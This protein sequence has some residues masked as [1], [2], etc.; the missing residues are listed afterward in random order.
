MRF[1]SKGTILVVAATVVVGAAGVVIAADRDSGGERP[2]RNRQVVT[3]KVEWR[4]LESSLVVR[5]S[6]VHVDEVTIAA[7]PRAEGQSASVVTGAPPAA[8]SPV[9]AGRSIIEINGRPIVV[10][11]MSVPLFRDI[12][13]GTTGPDVMSLQQELG[14]LGFDVVA[15][16]PGAFGPASQGAV[17]DLFEH[18]GYEPGYVAGSRAAFDAGVAEAERAA[19]RA[20]DAANRSRASGVA[21]PGLDAAV[22]TAREALTAFTTS[23]GV[24]LRS[25]ET[26]R[27]PNRPAVVVGTIPS[28]GDEVAA[29]T[30]VMALASPQPGVQIDLTAAQVPAIT[31]ASVVA[32]NGAYSA[33]CKPGR[34][35]AHAPT[36]P[37]EATPSATTGSLA[38]DVEQAGPDP[39]EANEEAADMTLEV[40]CDPKPGLEAVG[41]DAV[42][43]VKTKIAPEG[44]VVPATAVISTPSG[45]SFVEVAAPGGFRRLAVGTVAEAGG[46]V[47]IEVPNGTLEA[48]ARVRVRRS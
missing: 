8:G 47:A 40:M 38:P 22:R 29:D 16:A 2:K 48:G 19:D 14:R 1:R 4:S 32:V 10:L 41:T 27:I 33:T 46:F 44:P 45:R 30:P 15:D 42:A 7:P 18:A 9:A 24:E 34:L 25:N 37:E 43:T 39:G 6:V 31:P 35:V 28:V 20:L 13:P 26:T 23:Q 5:A 3:A 12:T 17:A 36:G 11:A 21:D